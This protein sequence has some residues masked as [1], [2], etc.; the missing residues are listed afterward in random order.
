MSEF[1]ESLLKEKGIYYNYSGADVLVKCLNP[2][3]DDSNPSLRIDKVTGAFH[4]FSC[5]F[6]GN[7]F[8]YFGVLTNQSFLKVAKLKEKLKQL[9]ID[10]DGL[11]IPPVSIPYTRSY[12]G[13]SAATLKRFEAFYLPGESKEMRGFEDRIIFPIRDITNKIVMF[14]GRHTLSDGNPRYLN[15]PSGVSVPLFPNRLVVRRNSIILVEGI[16]DMLNCQDKGL[17]NTVC[18]FGT[19]TLAKTAKEK[20]LPF[21]AQGV[22]KIYI[23][24]DGDEA[25]RKAAK[26]LKPIIE[27]LEYECEIIQLEDDQDPG[28]MSQEYVDS[29]EE[30]VNANST[31]RQG[32]E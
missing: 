11:E 25:G 7:I 21:R 20:L 2:D 27:A 6:K 22:S 18:T 17:D 19:N 5:G 31:N 32:S 3:H 23:M 12:R 30:Y 8:R 24:F 1:V 4:C 28:E 14:L 13:I 15:F 9:K 10:K 29:I 26:E 16:F